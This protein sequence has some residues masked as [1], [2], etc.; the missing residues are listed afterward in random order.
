MTIN[1]TKDKAAVLTEMR[2]RSGWVRNRAEWREVL[3]VAGYSGDPDAAVSKGV[4]V[5]QPH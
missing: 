3:A 1:P 2:R 4:V 5:T